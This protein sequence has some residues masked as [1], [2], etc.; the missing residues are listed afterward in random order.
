MFLASD[1]WARVKEVFAAARA[2]PPD[3]RRAYLADTCGDD[4]ALRQEVESLLASDERAKS[5][6]EA[7]AFVGDD[8]ARDQASRTME[9][10]RLGVYQ[11][12]ELL[13]AG[14]MGEVYRARDTKL[15]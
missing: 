3:R 12:Q 6:L 5:F 4:D 11:V 7:P 10:R 14:G 13:G 2:L 8:P 9:G 1:N 15:E